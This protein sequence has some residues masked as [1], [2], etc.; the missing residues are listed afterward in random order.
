M[1]QCQI[2]IGG[3]KE[4]YKNAPANFFDGTAWKDE[5][6]R[7]DD[8][9]AARQLHTF[10]EGKDLPDA[11]LLVKVRSHLRRF[12]L[13]MLEDR[14]RNLISPLTYMSLMV[15][16]SP[17]GSFGIKLVGVSWQY[18]LEPAGLRKNEQ[19]CPSL[20]RRSASTGR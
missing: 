14:G 6:R 7:P 3:K 8:L 18:C 19:S 10:L 4:V 11:A 5:M 9:D 1:R 12:V 20:E 15:M 17:S 2:F 16:T 13:P